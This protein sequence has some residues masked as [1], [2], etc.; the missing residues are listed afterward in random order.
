M[1]SLL[2]VRVHTNVN[3]SGAKK[4][5]KKTHMDK[6]KKMMNDWNYDAC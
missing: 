5:L 1:R 6:Y 3:I 2:Y 4:I